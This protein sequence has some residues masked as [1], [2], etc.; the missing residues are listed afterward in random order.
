MATQTFTQ[1]TRTSLLTLGTLATGTFI[2][3]STLDLSASI[4][5]DVVVEV[6]WDHSGTP[7]GNEQMLVYAQVSGDN[8]AFTSGPTSGTTATEEQDLLF[9][10]ASPGN[11][12]NT[13]RKQFSLRAAGI[14]IAR[15][16]KVVVKNDS[17]GA[18][19]SGTVYYWTVANTI[20]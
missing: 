19:T 6:E 16:L 3:S 11:D 20:A 13:H 10:G 15:Y 7:S 18:L 1:G 17:G 14:P 12:T 9:V 5:Y 4:P 2:A 8:S